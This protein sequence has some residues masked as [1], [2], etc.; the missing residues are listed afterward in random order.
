MQKRPFVAVTAGIL[1]MLGLESSA[2]P[3][4]ARGFFGSITWEMPDDYRF[5]GLSGIEVSADGLTFFALS[6]AGGIIAGQFVRDAVG[7]II[8]VNAAPVRPLKARGHSMLANGRTDAE[9]LALAPDGSLYVSFERA[10]RVLHY[11]DPAA[12]ATN[13]PEHPDFARMQNNSSLEALAIDADGTLFTLPERSG[14]T[15]KPFPVYRFRDGVWDQTLNV[16]R[17]GTFL[18]VGADIGPD[19]RFYLLER[20]FTGIAGF[21]TRLRSFAITETAMTDERLHMQSIRGQHDNLEGV[22]VWRDAQG[23][24]RATM[25]S[26]DNF[27]FFQSTQIVEYLLDDAGQD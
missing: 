6:D 3:P 8:S 17:S 23:R 27:N 24:L 22:S 15:E 10:A 14:G 26:D 20:Q 21:A 18:A 12:S 16:P 9:G 11:A 5:G 25:V 4:H 2:S 1:L 19:G 13:L 7:R